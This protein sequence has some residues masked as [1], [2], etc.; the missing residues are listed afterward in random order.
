MNLGQKVMDQLEGL[1]P[2]KDDKDS[3]FQVS[4]Q[5]PT[6]LTETAVGVLVMA[7]HYRENAKP[8]TDTDFAELTQ[9]FKL[10]A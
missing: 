1:L 10:T 5:S 8:P 6:I 4:I 7:I 9:R 2:N 3:C